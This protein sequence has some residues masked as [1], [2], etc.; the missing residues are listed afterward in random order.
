MENESAGVDAGVSV[1]IL[2]IGAG[3]PGRDRV[4]DHFGTNPACPCRNA[5]SSA[6]NTAR[7]TG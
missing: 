7:D 2:A 3:K 4:I 5:N 6:R 1:S